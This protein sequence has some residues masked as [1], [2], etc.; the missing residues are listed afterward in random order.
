MKRQERLERDKA[1]AA[2]A[3]D[4]SE[5]E[6]ETEK[7][8]RLRRTEQESDLTHAEELFGDI[9]L[10]RGRGRAANNGSAG[11]HKAMV[12]GD[13]SDPTKTIDLSELALFNPTTKDQFV[14]LTSTLVPLLA[15]HSKKP[16][17]TMWAQDFA[18]QLVRELPS[19][20]IKKV[21]SALTTLSNEK[22]KEERLA[23]KGSKKTKAA[24]TKVSLVTARNDRVDVTTSYDNGDGLDDDDFM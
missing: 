4:G 8:A 3:A 7:R 14:Q 17:F 2:A 16:Y 5:N 1:A 20:E 9:D 21:A 18:K 23:D 10:Q 15:R 19:A 13:G 11:L 12:V 24:K 6:D 22:M